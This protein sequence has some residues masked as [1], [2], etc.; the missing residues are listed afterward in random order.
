MIDEQL[1]EMQDDQNWEKS[2]QMNIETEPPL[3]VLKKI[4]LKEKKNMQVI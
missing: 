3:H 2:I 4:N 1:D